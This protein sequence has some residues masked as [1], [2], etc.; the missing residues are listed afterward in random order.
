MNDFSLIE[1][2]LSEASSIAFY[3]RLAARLLAES[4]M[5][6]VFKAHPW[7][8]KRPNLLAPVTL[9]SMAAFVAALEPGYRARIKLM[10]SEPIS[11]LFGH[12]DWVVGLC[13][14]GL[15]EACQAGFKPLQAG[16]AF[17]GGRG[18]T[19]DFATADQVANTLIAQDLP[20]R[21]TLDE[22]RQFEDFLVQAL[23]L[24]LVGNEPRE[25]EKAWQLLSGPAGT[26][27][28]WQDA[29]RWI[30]ERP[31][32]SGLAPA[33]SI[34]Q[35]PASWMRLAWSSLPRLP[36]RAIHKRD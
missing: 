18:F 32:P 26:I 12:A 7:E 35:N 24:H 4:E 9:N 1:T 33:L 6:I 15:L 30:A 11:A 20:A 17:F 10:E 31:A 16:G 21:L 14:Q 23:V 28:S 5:T 27:Y 29:E 2:P 8:R 13:S 36:A 19:H 34:L 3:R 22:Y 25:S